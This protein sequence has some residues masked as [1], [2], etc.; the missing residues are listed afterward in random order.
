V[1]FSRLSR[2]ANVAF[3]EFGDYKTSVFGGQALSIIEG[4]GAFELSSKGTSLNA[5]FNGTA[6]DVSGA[7]NA[8]TPS[9]YTLWKNTTITLFVSAVIST[10]GFLVASR[11]RIREYLNKG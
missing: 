4:N 2:K 7:R 3:V 10:L 9:F 5:V 8:L 1:L 11:A 6:E